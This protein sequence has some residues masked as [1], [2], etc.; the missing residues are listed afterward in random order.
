M[1]GGEKG[2]LSGVQKEIWDRDITKAKKDLEKLQN[3]RET[4]REMDYYPFRLRPISRRLKRHDIQGTRHYH[5]IHCYTR[6]FT[7]FNHRTS[8]ERW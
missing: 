8:S 7:H 1:N 5:C 6:W 2:T 3:L 4:V